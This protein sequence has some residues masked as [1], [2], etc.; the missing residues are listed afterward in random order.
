MQ[1][2]DLNGATGQILTLGLTVPQYASTTHGNCKPQHMVN[3]DFRTL[4]D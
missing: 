4:D 1:I 3:K 2:A